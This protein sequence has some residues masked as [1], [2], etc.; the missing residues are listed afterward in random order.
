MIL[1]FDIGGTATKIALFDTNHSLIKTDIIDYH[2]ALIESAI[3]KQLI[4]EKIALFQSNFVITALSF[5]TCGV[6]NANGTISGLSAILNYEGF[7][8]KKELS[9]YNLPISV[10]NDANCSLVAENQYGSAQGYQ[11]IITMVLGTGIGG[12]L[13]INGKLLNGLNGEFGCF[14]ASNHVNEPYQNLSQV[15]SPRNVEKRLNDLLASQGEQQ[16][17]ENYFQAYDKQLE[18]QKEFAYLDEMLFNLAKTI[19]NISF[20]ITP[21]IFLIGGGISANQIFMKHLQKYVTRIYADL[22]MPLTFSLKAATFKN[23]ANLH[24]AYFLAL[25]NKTPLQVEL[26]NSLETN[27]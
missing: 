16:K 10:E 3:L 15:A 22:G 25:N 5:A 26:Y 2:E 1:T 13:M 19:V 7:N 14:L 6:V 21:E 17:L 18:P 20:T 11:N 23:E 24:G 12:A 27:V 9:C 4:K 8:W